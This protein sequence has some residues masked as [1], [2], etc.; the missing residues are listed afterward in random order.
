VS[1][2]QS[3]AEPIELPVVNAGRDEEVASDDGK[4]FKRER[5][6]TFGHGDP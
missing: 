5:L 4:A 1:V 6:D 2:S 3:E